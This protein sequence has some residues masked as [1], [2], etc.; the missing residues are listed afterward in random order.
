MKVKNPWVFSSRMKSLNRKLSNLVG[1]FVDDLY[2]DDVKKTVYAIIREFV[3]KENLA[4]DTA[5]LIKLDKT[6]S[7]PI[8]K[9]I[10]I[11]V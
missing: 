8:F 6:K 10:Q 4:D 1:K 7:T 2:T 3:A 5:F 9:G 11:V